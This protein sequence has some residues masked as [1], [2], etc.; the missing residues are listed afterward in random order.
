[1]ISLIKKR[2]YDLA[3]VSNKC[4]VYYN[5]VKIECKNFEDYINLYHF[6]GMTDKDKDDDN[7][8]ENNSIDNNDLNDKDEAFKLFYEYVSD[9]WEVGFMYAPDNGNEQISFVNGICTYHGGTHVN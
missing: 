4:K 6:D 2:V 5:D 1:M 7:D 8:N 9:T 3:G